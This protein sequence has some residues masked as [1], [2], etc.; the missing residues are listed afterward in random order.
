MS[1]NFY[2][3]SLSRTLVRI[4]WP[5]F[6]GTRSRHTPPQ[7]RACGSGKASNRTTRR[8]GD[9]LP[10]GKLQKTKM[11]WPLTWTWETGGRDAFVESMSRLASNHAPHLRTVLTPLVNSVRV[12]GP[13]YPAWPNDK[14]KLVG[15]DGEDLGPFAEGALRASASALAVPVPSP[16]RGFS[17]HRVASKRRQRPPSTSS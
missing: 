15:L 11:G 14:P 5:A 17:N 7:A 9:L 2:S 13:F 10:D 6:S 8:K 1:E 3:A 4:P 16:T 12:S